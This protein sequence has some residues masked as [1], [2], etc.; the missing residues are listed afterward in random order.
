MTRLDSRLKNPRTFS[1]ISLHRLRPAA[2][3]LLVV[4][5]S[6]PAASSSTP[7]GWD[8]NEGSEREKVV[9]RR[10]KRRDDEMAVA[11]QER[12]RVSGETAVA[13]APAMGRAARS[14][15]GLVG[16][17]AAEERE[18]VSG[19][20]DAAAGQCAALEVLEGDEAGGLGRGG[21]VAEDVLEEALVAGERDGA[22]AGPRREPVLL[23][24][25]PEQLPEHGVVQV[26][27]PHHE[28]PRRAAHAHR[29]VPRRDRRAS[30]R[31][32]PPPP[33]RL[34]QP[35]DVPDLAAAFRHV[36]ARASE[37]ARAS[38]LTA[39]GRRRSI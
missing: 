15:D 27:R 11:V 23:L 39:A 25:L 12:E 24:R 30:R 8:W 5:V 21:E 34:P 16:G 3:L 26:R 14:P 2:L 13:P 37:R 29:H 36:D 17:D 9:K 6:V 20:G 31:A 22:R 4:E 19:G 38:S 10:K 28:P 32:G 35:H 33:Q 18:R 1:A 7:L